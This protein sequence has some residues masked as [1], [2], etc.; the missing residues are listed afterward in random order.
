MKLA[1][2]IE[3]FLVSVSAANLS[4]KTYRRYLDDLREL[5]RYCTEREIADLDAIGP[6]ELRA[7]MTY[8]IQRDNQ[9]HPGKFLS[10]YS[11]EGKYRTIKRFFNFCHLEEKIGSNP[12]ARVAHPK[13]PKR[14]VNRLTE[15]Q[16]ESVLQS[17]SKTRMPERNIALMMLLV[18]S[19]LR[20]GEIIGLRVGDLDLDVGSAVVKGKGNKMRLVP[21]NQATIEAMQRWL[22]VRETRLSDQVFVNEW[23][24]PI[25]GDAILALFKRLR[26]KLGLPRFYPLLMRHTFAALYL[27]RV[28]D[29]KTLQQILGHSRSS[30]TLDIYV[31]FNF[32]HLKE[33]HD[34]AFA[35]RRQ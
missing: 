1:P 14:I 11:V 15:G 21:I 24:G 31:D 26:D 32:E 9:A 4:A 23:D 29:Y 30:T 33:M 19:G 18:Y 34:Q 13:V 22:E 28:H 27:K 12:I 5:E 7:F 17:V 8:L 6:D 10:P 25:Q 3:Q 2:A 16:V 20:R 35:R